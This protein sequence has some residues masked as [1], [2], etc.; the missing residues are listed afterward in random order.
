M[1]CSVET[2]HEGSMRFLLSLVAA[3]ALTAC[4]TLPAASQPGHEGPA[5]LGQATYVGGPVVTPLGVIEDSRCPM[6]ARCVWAGR[7][8]LRVR[9][10]T[11]GRSV[12][13]DLILGTPVPIADGTLALT[14]A[15]PDRRT[16]LTIR[17]SDYR[18][19]FEFQGGL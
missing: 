9:I 14:S 7:V 5:A 18:F 19:T 13:R 10:A 2:E 15:T 3:A 8:V 4:A 16:D 6:N 12:E 1:T 17:P 11:G